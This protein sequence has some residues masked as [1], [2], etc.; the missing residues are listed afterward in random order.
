MNIL[1]LFFGF[2]GRIGRGLF[3]LINVALSILA[4][5]A[6]AWC[7]SV[8]MKNGATSVDAFQAQMSKMVPG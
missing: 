4:L 2:Q 1:N 7:G 5:C 3:W 6:T 8:A